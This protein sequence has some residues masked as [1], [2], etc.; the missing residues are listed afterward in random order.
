MARR[1]IS[2][3]MASQRSEHVLFPA[4]F[5]SAL[6]RSHRLN[7]LRAHAEGFGKRKDGK[8]AEDSLKSTIEIDRFIDKLRFADDN[9][10]GEWLPSLQRWSAVS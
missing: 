8:A 4:S 6:H 5:L 1:Q 10:V 7:G 2:H 9:E 3:T